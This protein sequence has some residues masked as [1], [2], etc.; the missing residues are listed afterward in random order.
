M[1]EP[2]FSEAHEGTYPTREAW[3]EEVANEVFEWPRQHEAIIEPL[4]P[5]VSLNLASLAL[6]LEQHRHVVEGDEG[7]YVFNPDA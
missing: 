2:C 3:A 6:D 4:R 1:T 5:H 7:V